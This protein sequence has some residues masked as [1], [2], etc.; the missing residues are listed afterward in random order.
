MLKYRVLV[1]LNS[2][3]DGNDST[4]PIKKYFDY[5]NVLVFANNF[6]KYVIVMIQ[7]TFIT[8]LNG[9]NATVFESEKFYH[10]LAD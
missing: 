4:T 3:Y 6:Y 9:T 10:K 5:H 2:Y 8:F 1:T 7:P